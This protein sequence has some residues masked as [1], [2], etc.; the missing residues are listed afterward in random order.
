MKNSN[1]SIC[2][3]MH[4]LLSLFDWKERLIFVE[5]KWREWEKTQSKVN[6]RK[7]NRA[8]V[9]QV[10]NLWNSCICSSFFALRISLVNKNISYFKVFRSTF[11]WKTSGTFIWTRIL[12]TNCIQNSIIRLKLTFSDKNVDATRKKN[13]HTQ[14]ERKK[15]A[16]QK[17]RA[18][19][20]SES[21]WLCPFQISLLD[22]N[23]NFSRNA[24]HSTLYN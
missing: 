4:G 14:C 20:Y 1:K 17:L 12:Q 10:K 16:V 5:K 18:E 22:R 9:D 6:I 19:P 7:I 3:N 15:N 11:T 13:T 2:E 8:T 21:L 24:L 23:L